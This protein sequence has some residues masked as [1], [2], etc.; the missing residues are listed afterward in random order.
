MRRCLSGGGNGSDEF[1]LIKGSGMA[2]TNQ[3]AGSRQDQ[4]SDIQN[5]TLWAQTLMSFQKVPCVDVRKNKRMEGIE[6][7]QLGE[8]T[9]SPNKPIPRCPSWEKLEQRQVTDVKAGQLS[10]PFH[11]KNPATAPPCPA[12]LFTWKD[13]VSGDG[14]MCS[15]TTPSLTSACMQLTPEMD[16]HLADW[17]K[18][19]NPLN[20]VIHSGI[21]SPS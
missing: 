9:Q 13:P 19:C 2:G 5:H 6:C 14:Q 15:T 21:S 8:S 11:P 4:A 1:L 12:P 20:T 7:A 17:S 16:V 3:S 10:R 18:P